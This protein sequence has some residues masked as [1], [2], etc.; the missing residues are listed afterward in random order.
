[1]KPEIFANFVTAIEFEKLSHLRFYKIFF[2]VF[3]AYCMLR[4]D[5]DRMKNETIIV[6]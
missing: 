6:C 1:M 5:W 2:A 4:N 3:E